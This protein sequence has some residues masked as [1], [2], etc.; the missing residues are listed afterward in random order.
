MNATMRALVWGTMPIGSL[1][2]G[3]LG[4]AIGLVPALVAGGLV[5]LAAALWLIALPRLDEVGVTEPAGLLA[6]A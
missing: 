5:A 3:A 6:A 1:A 2:G 4:A